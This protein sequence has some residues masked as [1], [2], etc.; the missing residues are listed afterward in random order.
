MTK[1]LRA[2][3][4]CEVEMPA[5]YEISQAYSKWLDK[6]YDQETTDEAVLEILEGIEGDMQEKAENIAAL[7][8]EL[9]AT[10]AAIKLAEERQKERRQAMEN[11]AARLRRYLMDAMIQTGNT[12][13]ETPRFRIS[14]RNNQE[15]VD[16]LD[17]AAIP[18]DYKREIPVRHEP[19]KTLIKQ[20]LKDGFAVPGCALKRTQSLSIK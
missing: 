5:L 4:F 12:K 17:E 3:F 15:S 20:A 7:C 6:L 19:D 1:R 13:F 14:I 16:I 2:L 18:A 9:E 10:A 8:T 11:K